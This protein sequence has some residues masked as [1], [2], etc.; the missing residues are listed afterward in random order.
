VLPG[1]TETR[2]MRNIE[3]NRSPGAPEKAREM[4]L[5]GLPLKRYGTPKE[6]ANLMLFLSSDEASICTG[7]VYLADGGMSAI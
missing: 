6:I 3:E 7:G 5:A 2:M 1:P 4:I